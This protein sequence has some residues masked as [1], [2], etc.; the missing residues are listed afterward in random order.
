MG[1]GMI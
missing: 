1:L